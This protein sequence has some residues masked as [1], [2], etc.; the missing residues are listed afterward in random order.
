MVSFLKGNIM[1]GKVIGFINQKGG[2][3]KSTYSSTIARELSKTYT[4]LM[5]DFDGQATL[6]HLLNL[7]SVYD[8]SDLDAY[9]E[10]NS[11]IKIFNRETIEPLDITDFVKQTNPSSVP[12]KELHLIPSPGNKMG[13]AAEGVAGG[14]DLLLKK[15][16]EK[17]KSN[18]DYI[19][20]DSLPSTG[21]LFKNV[22][23]ASNILVI[24]IETKT[25]AIAGANEFLGVLNEVIGDYD[26]NYDHLF[27]L[28][29]K[30]NKQR[31]DDKETLAEIE[32]S[33]IEAIRSYEF[34]SKLDITVLEAI[35]E[36]SVFSNA[37]AVR[38]FL[39]D[40]VETYENGKKD[41]LYLI[42]KLCKRIVKS[43]KK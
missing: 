42:E 40:F 7:E 6:T 18:Y 24:P 4:V 14:R 3:G 34:I 38:Y 12:I 23:L 28:P 26:V 41:I 33:Y 8:R 32:T 10:Q 36:R 37:Q 25:N 9:M 35:P 27:V 29:T 17:I 16:I 19:I 30:Y 5:I 13:S 39:Q 15:Y 11:I 20:I 22:L 31:R 43:V 1:L 2:V 21:T